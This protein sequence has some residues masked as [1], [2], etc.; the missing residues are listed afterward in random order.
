MDLSGGNQIERRRNSGYVL[1]Q[2]HCGVVYRAAKVVDIPLHG[3]L[4][5]YIKIAAAQAPDAVLDHV[6]GAL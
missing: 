3:K 2:L 1:L 6:Q 5:L 4:D